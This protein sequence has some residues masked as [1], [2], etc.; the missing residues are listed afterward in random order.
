MNYNNTN[1]NT[2]VFG[3]IHGS[4][5]WEKI[6]EQHPD[7]KFIFLG[8]YMDPYEKVSDESLLDNFQNM[9]ALKKE[10]MEDVILLLGNHDVHYYLA[11]ALRGSR[12][13]DRIAPLLR[14]L[15]LEHAALFQNA[16]QIDNYIFTHA[17]ISQEWFTN[18][19]KGDVHKNIAEQLNN[20]TEKQEDALFYC[21]FYRGGNV[22]NG[23]IFWADSEELH[24]PLIGYTQVVGHNRVSGITEH[25]N[26]G[27][28]IIFCDCFYNGIYLEI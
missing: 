14:I 12:R 5:Y 2:I 13:N 15:F 25:S 17:G 28:R 27:E 8:D 11:K 24:N 7:S 22:P 16:Y 4:N 18:D 6:V 1:Y 20:P 21:G 23:G 26:N 19:F 9:I 3:D 10:R